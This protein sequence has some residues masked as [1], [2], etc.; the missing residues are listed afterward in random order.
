MNPKIQTLIDG[1][2]PTFGLQAHIDLKNSITNYK[3]LLKLTKNKSNSA[4]I[5]V[6]EINIM[7]KFKNLNNANK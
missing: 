7:N 2:R 1:F 4:L 3:R 6:A 5:E